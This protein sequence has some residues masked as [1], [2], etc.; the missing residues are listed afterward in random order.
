MLPATGTRTNENIPVPKKLLNSN[1]DIHGKHLFDLHHKNKLKL[2]KQK[3][4]QHLAQLMTIYFIFSLCFLSVIFVSRCPKT[5]YR[6][7]LAALRRT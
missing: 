5:T 4:R 6:F 2:D 7:V 3:T 1:L